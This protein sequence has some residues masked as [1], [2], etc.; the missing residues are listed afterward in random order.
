MRQL[1]ANILGMFCLPEAANN[2][3]AY[4]IYT[5]YLLVNTPNSRNVSDFFYKTVPV[6]LLIAQ[7][8]YLVKNCF[9]VF[10]FSQ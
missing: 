7:G 6:L 4:G 10:S 1:P 9:V 5:N 3:R 2:A 8:T